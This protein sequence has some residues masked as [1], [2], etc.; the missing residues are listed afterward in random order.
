MPN[1]HSDG[2]DK[3]ADNWMEES[4]FNGEVR[5]GN[6]NVQVISI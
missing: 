5:A 2:N 3:E 1:R 6:T 4:K